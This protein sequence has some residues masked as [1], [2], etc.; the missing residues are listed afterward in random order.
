MWYSPPAL[1]VLLY[2]IIESINRVIWGIFFIMKL[3]GK[4]NLT[5]IW[6]WIFWSLQ[7][8]KNSPHFCRAFWSPHRVRVVYHRRD[9]EF[10][11]LSSCSLRLWGEWMGD[12]RNVTEELL[13]F[14]S[15]DLGRVPSSA[16]FKFY[17]LGQ[18]T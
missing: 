12:N 11:E 9:L 1:A 7:N 17:N 8:C 18:V 3:I 13:D 5:H 10:P 15:E 16:M 14:D 4:N 2:G 6:R